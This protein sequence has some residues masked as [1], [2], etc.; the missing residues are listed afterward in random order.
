M[1][2]ERDILPKFA[3]EKGGDAPFLFIKHTLMSK[4]RYTFMTLA[5]LCA[6]FA[7]GGCGSDHHDND[8][9]KIY[10]VS[11]TVTIG[12]TTGFSQKEYNTLLIV[13]KL[14]QDA[15][16]E[17][18]GRETA[19]LESQTAHD[20]RVMAACYT[21]QASV[22]TEYT[23]FRGEIYVTNSSTKKILYTFKKN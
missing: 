2:C 21:V 6:A 13:S 12:N 20:S 23:D 1:P 8:E 11:Y 4:I 9:D 7:L 18:N 19:T 15:V 14:Y 16:D 17:A 3:P 5:L 22:E 10:Q